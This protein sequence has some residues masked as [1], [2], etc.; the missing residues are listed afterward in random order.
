[1]QQKYNFLIS[2]NRKTECLRIS[3]ATNLGQLRLPHVIELKA[4]IKSDLHLTSNNFLLEQTCPSK[5]VNLVSLGFSFD[6]GTLSLST[7][8]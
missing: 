2:R 3:F 6:H 4:N 8:R 7:L 1:M 5:L